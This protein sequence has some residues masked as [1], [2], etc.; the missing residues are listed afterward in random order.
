MKRMLVPAVALLA[1]ALAAPAAAQKKYDP[2][3][4]DSEIKIGNT[5]PYSGP[6]SAYGTIGKTIA[7]APPRRTAPSARPSPR[8][9]RC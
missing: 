6:A 4:T 2:G 3:A 8:T 7:A 9:S 5:N 1:A